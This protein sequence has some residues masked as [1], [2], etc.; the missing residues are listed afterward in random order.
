MTASREEFNLYNP[1]FVA[2]ALEAAVRGH[3]ERSDGGM[4]L[5][6]VHSAATIGLFRHL[7]ADLPTTIRTH[8]A[9]WVTNHPEFRPEFQRLLVGGFPA[10]QAGFQFGLGH[11]TIA[12][13][14]SLATAPGNRR[15]P[16]PGLSEET[17][18]VLYT[19]RFVGRWF[20]KTASPPTILSLL[21]FDS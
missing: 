9:T 8:F 21:G 16:S 1:A 13:T 10:L 6:L 12:L 17:N 20:A 2:L 4:S 11:G 15:R 5:P 14:G 3:S 19:S 18:E 7:R